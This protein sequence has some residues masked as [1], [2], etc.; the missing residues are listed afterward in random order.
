MIIADVKGHDD[1]SNSQDF[2]VNN[3]VFMIKI[4]TINLKEIKSQTF[5]LT[6]IQI[7]Y[8]DI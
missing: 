1:P 3:L 7:L 4:P 8:P 5:P 2:Q 6:W